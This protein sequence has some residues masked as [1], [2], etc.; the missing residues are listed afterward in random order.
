MIPWLSPGV[1]AHCC[2]S[3]STIVHGHVV[4]SST[5]RG[6]TNCV[7]APQP[8]QVQNKPFDKQLRL[9]IHCI[10]ARYHQFSGDLEQGSFNTGQLES[11][12][13]PCP[14]DKQGH[15]PSRS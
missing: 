4:P 13:S 11:S 14:G 12:S 8:L 7:G 15:E 5:T 2:L 1:F 10:I 6:R 3:S 9:I